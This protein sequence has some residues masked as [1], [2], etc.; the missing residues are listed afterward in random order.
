MK[1][2]SQ[3]RDQELSIGDLNGEE[4]THVITTFA[5]RIGIERWREG[6][7]GWK[8]ISSDEF[9][10]LLS[11]GDWPDSAATTE[12]L[13]WCSEP[14]SHREFRR[15]AE[16]SVYWQKDSEGPQLWISREPSVP[17]SDSGVLD[18][19]ALLYALLSTYKL[20]VS[21]EHYDAHPKVLRKF[22]RDLL[23]WKLKRQIPTLLFYAIGLFVISINYWSN[24]EELTENDVKNLL[25][26]VGIVIF[27]AIASRIAV[28]W[29][30][31]LSG[32]VL[33]MVL[34]AFSIFLFAVVLSEL[35]VIDGSFVSDDQA[36]L[37]VCVILGI[38]V[39]DRRRPDLTIGR[40]FRRD[41]VTVTYRHLIV[42]ASLVVAPT[43]GTLKLTQY[44]IGTIVEDPNSAML[45]APITGMVVVAL[46]EFV[47]RE[48]ER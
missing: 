9:V 16:Y 48:I 21:D 28:H 39:A 32:L 43:F 11:A 15:L 36:A 20:Y 23:I 30:G 8:V 33:F 26:F 40:L 37:A 31:L 38:F 34:F 42:P 47:R 4:L 45:L 14:L 19:R 35:G 1:R 24:R 46:L 41:A 29:F 12:E 17:S 2:T 7:A 10:D 6:N 25:V 3:G 5:R 44:V 22:K 18:V 13:Q 27:S